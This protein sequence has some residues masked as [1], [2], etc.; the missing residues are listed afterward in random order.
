MAVARD[1]LSSVSNAPSSYDKFYDR[2]TLVGIPDHQ[3]TFSHKFAGN[4]QHTRRRLIYFGLKSRANIVKS[5][6]SNNAIVQHYSN[7]LN[8]SRR[9]VAGISGQ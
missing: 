8:I 2:L 5:M 7:I 1:L 3:S 6:L 9:S 4:S